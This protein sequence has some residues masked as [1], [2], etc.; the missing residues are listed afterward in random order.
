M[1]LALHWIQSP[2]FERDTAYVSNNYLIHILHLLA[3][4]DKIP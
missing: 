1:I 4:I 2:P 3:D